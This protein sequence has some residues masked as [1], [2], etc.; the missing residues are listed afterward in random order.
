MK[1]GKRK[2]RKVNNREG[3]TDR[4]EAGTI[5]SK[6]G[7]ASSRAPS[8]VLRA[9]VSPGS[10]L[11]GGMAIIEPSMCASRDAGHVAACVT[12]RA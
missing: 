3:E 1:K 6:G 11:P 8:C 9:A 5:G 10:F 12:L 7:A 4:H 2:G